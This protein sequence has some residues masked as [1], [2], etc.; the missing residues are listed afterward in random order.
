MQRGDARNNLKNKGHG[1]GVSR[2][3][4]SCPPQGGRTF[5]RSRLLKPVG[6]KRQNRSKRGNGGRP[7]SA[8]SY[9]FRYGLRLSVPV[10]SWFP[11]VKR[12]A[13]PRIAETVVRTRSRPWSTR[14]RAESDKSLARC[15]RLLRVSSPLIGAKRIP[16]PRPIPNPAKKDFIGTL[17][18]VM[19]G[20]TGLICRQLRK[21]RIY[22]EG[23]RNRQWPASFPPENFKPDKLLAWRGE[24]EPFS[25]KKFRLFRVQLLCRYLPSG[26]IGILFL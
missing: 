5:P 11:P 10:D 20:K 22:S 15:A 14:S 16:K 18:R 13:C 6:A 12:S 17:L 8:A 3:A 23:C 7:S 1:Q 21:M 9:A 19:G 25:R 2:R 24:H 26:G 4:P